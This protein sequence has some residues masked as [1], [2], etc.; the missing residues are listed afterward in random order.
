MPY[1]KNANTISLLEGP[2]LVK[3]FYWSTSTMNK[4]TAGQYLNRLGVFSVFL[5][6]ELDGL[7]ID[8]LV[9]KIKE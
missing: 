8:I 7:T 9:N 4:A 1:S 6:K 5:N 3:E 2:S